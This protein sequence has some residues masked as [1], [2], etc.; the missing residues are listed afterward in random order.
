MIVRGRNRDT[1][2][3]SMLVRE[4]PSRRDAMER[5]LRAEPGTVSLRDLTA[6]PAGD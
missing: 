4:W 5:W 3:H 6:E 2:W 1:A